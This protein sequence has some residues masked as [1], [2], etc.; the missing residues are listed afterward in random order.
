MTLETIERIVTYHQKGYSMSRA[1]IIGFVIKMEVIPELLLDLDYEV[2]GIIRRQSTP[3]SQS[4]RY[5]HINNKIK[6]HYGDLL[7][8]H[9]LYRIMK[10]VRPTH[11]FNLAAMSH[12]RISFDVPS[13]TIQ[14]NALGVLNMLEA[15]RNLAPQAKFYQASSSEMFGNSVDEDNHQRLTTPMNPVDF[16]ENS[17]TNRNAKTLLYISINFVVCWEFASHGSPQ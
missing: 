13:F 8:E 6:T 9:S 16:A 10:E 5:E 17:P 2:H 12:V 4:T 11:I 3:E 15:T 7:D 1:L 14:T